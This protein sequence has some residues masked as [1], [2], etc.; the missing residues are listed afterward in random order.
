MIR[1][2]VIAGGGSAGWMAA[3]ALAGALGATG[4]RIILVESEEIGTVGVGEATIPPIQAFNRILGL[5]E[6]A[7]VRA[8]KGTFKLGIEF[9][10]WRR[11]GHRYFHPF[12][13]FGDDFG[14][15][16]FHQQWLRMRATGDTTPIGAYSLTQAAAGRNRFDRPPAGE[17]GSVFSTYAYAYHFDAGLY[18]RFL[19]THAEAAGVFRIE[20]RIGDVLRDDLTG[21]V[22]A[23]VLESGQRVEGDLF[24]DC[25]GFRALLIGGAMGI[26]YEDWSRWLPCDRAIAVPTAP[27]ANPPPFTRATAHQAGWQWRIPLQHRTGNGHVYASAYLDD[28]A[29]ER[30]LIDN[31][32]G[33][34]IGEPRRLCFTTGRRSRAW[35]GNVV[36]LGLASGFLEPLESTSLHLIQSGIVRLLSWFP[37]RRFDPALADAYNREVAREFE[38]I[39][40]FLVLHYH[41]TDRD[42][43]P[44]WQYCRSMKVPDGLAEKMAMFR[45]NGRLVQRPNDLFHDA[46]WLAVMLGQGVEPESYDPIAEAVVPDEAA[47]VLRGMRGV[48]QRTAEAMPRHAHF[49]DAQCRADQHG[50]EAP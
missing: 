42:D 36:S 26:G 1:S 39:R 12:G 41:A 13:R 43:L 6:A 33:P 49:I 23:L 14:M 24:L 19:R 10:N 35:A 31:L 30:V 50:G 17:N 46:N 32:D 11:Q 29:A 38:L 40:D 44:F 27:I 47:A 37:D 4:T 16:P 25:T 34:P 8:T 7:F 2:V 5:D 45:A 28:D 3:A 20:G 48:I 18:A 21:N 9:V 22:S 15:T